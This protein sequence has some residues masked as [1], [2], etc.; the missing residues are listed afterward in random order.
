[1]QLLN[2]LDDWRWQINEVLNM[3]N[4]EIKREDVLAKLY[5]N[6]KTHEHDQS[7]A[8][9]VWSGKI[10][11]RLESI[12]TQ[13]TKGETPQDVRDLVRDLEKPT[14]VLQAY[15]DAISMIEMDI[16]PTITLTA[17]EF[18]CYIQDRWSWKQNWSASNSKYLGH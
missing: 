7:K 14:D 2:E 16:R 17:E 6:R 15:D 1:M 9:K 3:R 10:K 13:L 12:L 11:D 5:E 4:V 8:L 18:K